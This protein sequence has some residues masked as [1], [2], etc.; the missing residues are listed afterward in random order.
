MKNVLLSLFILPLFVCAQKTHTV[1]AKET[2]FSIG[3]QYNVH[4][5]ELAAFNNIPYGT[6][7]NIGQVIKI[8]SKTTMAALPSTT[9]VATPEVKKEPVVATPEVKKEAKVPA[10]KK[11]AEKFT[12]VPVYHK[13][14]KKENL[15]QI[16]RQ[17]NKV[18][19]ADIKK[20]NNLSTDGLSEGMNLIVGYKKVS[21]SAVPKEE[22]VKQAPVIETV[23]TEIVKVAPENQPV[24]QEEVKP[25]VEKKPV[26]EVKPVQEIIPEKS[27]PLPPP[28]T[29]Q[30]VKSVLV[31]DFKGGYFKTQYSGQLSK[32]ESGMAAT[33]KSTSGWEDGK[34]YCLHNA[35]P[36]GTVI[37]ISAKSSQRTV[38]A[39]VLDVIPDLKKNDGLVILISNAA[40]EE[41]GVSSENIEVTVNY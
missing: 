1:G 6:G 32:E 14:Q 13:V 41:L 36:A 9:P 30:E 23:K 40:A 12:M 10:P 24:K 20:W 11:T 18:P 39:K 29:R 38:Y 21:T 37:K 28:D 31:K 4:P 7:L 16:S 34:Y 27:K 25:I 33:F 8:P 19:I 26:E 17:Y 2:L 3:R 5:R 15:Y 35:A 22:V